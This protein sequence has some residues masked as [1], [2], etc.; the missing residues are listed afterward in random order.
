M[1][2]VSDVFLET[3]DVVVGRGVGGIVRETVQLDIDVPEMPNFA[4]WGAWILGL[5]S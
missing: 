5:G 4:E 2:E 1:E 3:E